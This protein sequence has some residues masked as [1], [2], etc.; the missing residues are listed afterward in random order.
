MNRAKNFGTKSFSGGGGLQESKG[1]EDPK[2]EKMSGGG[3]RLSQAEL[4]ERSKRGLCFKC[5]EKWGRDHVCKFKHLQ[6]V[7]C[8]GPEEE[9]SEGDSEGEADAEMEFKTLKLSL[10]S[11]EGFTSNK[12][13]K[14]WGSIAGRKVL[15]L[16]DSGAT[17]NFISKELVQE[18]QLPVKSTAPYTVEIGTGELVT[19]KGVCKAVPLL[20]QGV[21]FH[22]NFFLMELGGTEVVLGMDWLASLGDIEANFRSL[23][24]KWGQG[25]DRVILKD[26]PSLCKG[27]ASLKTMLKFLQNEGEGFYIDFYQLQVNDNSDLPVLTPWDSLLEQ[28]DDVFQAPQGLPPKRDYDHA[29]VLKE[30][31]QIPNIRPYRYPYYQKNE[32]ENIVKEMLHAGIIRPSNSPFS[33]PVILVK[34]K[35]GGW[36]CCTDYRAL[37]KVTIPDKFPIPD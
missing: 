28:F 1:S 35:D 9:E 14:L 22:Q 8:E 20:V 31:A 25:K 4:E 6:L 15:I 32:I 21:Q 18:L 16:V 19:N 3:R 10:Q 24:I 33:S 7:L 34:K 2:S 17:S 26:E 13:F 36:C 11:K 37:N 12:S 30:G 27:T 29:I 5:G 23:I